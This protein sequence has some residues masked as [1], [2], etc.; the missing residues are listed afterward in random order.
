MQAGSGLSDISRAISALV[1]AEL[2]R[3]RHNAALSGSGTTLGMARIFSRPLRSA[4][5]CAGRS[6]R[7]HRPKYSAIDREKPCSLPLNG[8][9]PGVGGW[10]DRHR[11][12][13]VQQLDERSPGS[14]LDAGGSLVCFLFTFRHSA[15]VIQPRCQTRSRHSGGCKLPIRWT[16]PIPNSDSGMR[17]IRSSQMR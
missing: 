6:V 3:I 1:A 2:C 14:K 11:Y 12:S 16:A 10:N 4:F 17:R 9:S 5:F 7:R 15:K 13:A 8:R